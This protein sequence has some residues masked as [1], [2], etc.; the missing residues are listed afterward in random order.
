ME[1]EKLILILIVT[2]L[3][4]FIMTVWNWN[5]TKFAI[6]YFIIIYLSFHFLFASVNFPPQHTGTDYFL[7]IQVNITRKLYTLTNAQK[8]KS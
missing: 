3:K 6:I 1:G 2:F 8:N 5:E 7:K 4:Y